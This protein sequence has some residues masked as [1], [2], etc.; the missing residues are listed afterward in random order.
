M[1]CP[2]AQ[3]SSTKSLAE[4]TP[5]LVAHLDPWLFAYLSDACLDAI[6][7]RALLQH[8]RREATV[9]T[10]KHCCDR[11]VVSLP[12]E[13]SLY[14]TN[15]AWHGRSQLANCH[16]ITW[17]VCRRRPEFVDWRLSPLPYKRNC[18]GTKS[19]LAAICRILSRQEIQSTVLA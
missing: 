19:S 17:L 15:D 4:K 7:S 9:V 10:H 5:I 6:V 3:T 16:H 11:V 8:D 12:G 13:E 18:P 1:V 2:Q 14:L